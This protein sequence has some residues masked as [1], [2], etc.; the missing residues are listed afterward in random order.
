[1]FVGRCISPAQ[2]DLRMANGPRASLPYSN[3]NGDTP[4]VVFGTSRYANN[5]K[6]VAGRVA[7]TGKPRTRSNPFRKFLG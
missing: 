1:M 4:V 7:R 2:D 5:K 6:S 3:L